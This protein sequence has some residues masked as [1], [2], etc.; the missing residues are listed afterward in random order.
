MRW[1]ARSLAGSAIL[2]CASS[3]AGTAEGQRERHGVERP[4]HENS[5]NEKE[6][7]AE[8]DP[9]PHSNGT[10]SRQVEIAKVGLQPPR[11]TADY[12]VGDVSP[13]FHAARGEGI[14]RFCLRLDRYEAQG[15]D[16]YLRPAR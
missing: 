4:S 12:V 5:K 7:A 3:L 16:L 6:G 1:S 11:C 14:F 8:A 2:A 13:E 15:A 9:L 10:D